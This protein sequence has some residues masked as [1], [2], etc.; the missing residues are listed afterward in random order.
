MKSNVE[1]VFIEKPT[2]TTI[3]GVTFLPVGGP[4]GGVRV[5]AINPNGAGAG[6][7]GI[8]DIVLSVNGKSVEDDPNV[9]GNCS[10]SRLGPSS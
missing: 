6:K 8:D 2:Q 5:S 4:G 1:E 9:A 3:V 7:I 10:E